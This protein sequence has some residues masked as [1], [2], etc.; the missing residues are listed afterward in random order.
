M[1]LAREAF[2]KYL[3]LIRI[4]IS[5]HPLLVWWLKAISTLQQPWDL[6]LPPLTT[7]SPV[8]ILVT[9]EERGENP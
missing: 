7:S 2:F 1:F 4:T 3:L 5:A 6:S 9:G 8:T